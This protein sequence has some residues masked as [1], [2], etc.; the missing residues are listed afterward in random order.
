MQKRKAHVHYSS[1]QQLNAAHYLLVVHLWNAC[2][3]TRLATVVS[4]VSLK[5]KITPRW[6]ESDPHHTKNTHTPSSAPVIE[7]P[8]LIRKQRG[9]P[10]LNRLCIQVNYPLRSFLRNHTCQSA[11]HFN[12]HPQQDNWDLPHTQS[13]TNCFLSVC[14]LARAMYNGFLLME[15]SLGQTSSAE[16]TD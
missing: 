4:G 8:S 7:T 11:P 15:G 13:H 5:L 9:R 2:R 16:G 12:L 6:M 3:D 14:F 10:Y 1:R